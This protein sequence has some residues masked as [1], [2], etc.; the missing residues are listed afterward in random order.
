MFNMSEGVDE[1]ELMSRMESE[2]FNVFVGFLLVLGVEWGKFQV[3]DF[4]ILTLRVFF[5]A[6][7]CWWSD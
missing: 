7:S 2:I 6:L 3:V 4:S 5:Y 1:I